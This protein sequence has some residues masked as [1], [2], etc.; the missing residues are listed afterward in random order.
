MSVKVGEITF[1]IQ[2]IGARIINVGIDAPD[3]LPISFTVQNGEVLN[4]CGC[5]PKCDTE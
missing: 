2:R 4:S 3:E 1:H 5:E